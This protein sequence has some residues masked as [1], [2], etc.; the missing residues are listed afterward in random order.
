MGFFDFL[1]AEQKPIKEEI[2]IDFN[3]NSNEELLLESIKLMIRENQGS[4][5]LI[6]RKF[7]IGYNKAGKIIDQLEECGVVSAYKE[8]TY[9]EL[10]IKDVELAVEAINKY[11]TKKIN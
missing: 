6:Q 9:R 8:D 4:T 3:P 5:S 7:K 10:L 2:I 11:N 1:K